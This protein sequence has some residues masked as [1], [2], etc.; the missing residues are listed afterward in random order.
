MLKWPEKKKKFIRVFF[1]IFISSR[2]G[3][4]FKRKES[5]SESTLCN[6]LL[7]LILEY[8]VSFFSGTFKNSIKCAHC[9][10]INF[11]QGL[12]E[13]QKVLKLTFPSHHGIYFK[14]KVYNCE[15]ILFN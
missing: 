7:K 10:T 1:T 9:Q 15:S 4:Y 8:G 12:G 2:H 6:Q 13:V 5:N 3:I 11:V 14:Q